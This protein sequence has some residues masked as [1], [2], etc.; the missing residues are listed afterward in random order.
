MMQEADRE[1]VRQAMRFLVASG[2][3][4]GSL[5]DDLDARVDDLV[6]GA[7]A[8]LRAEI[9]EQVTADLD[10]PARREAEWDEE[11]VNDRIDEAFDELW[12]GEV[13]ALQNV[14]YTPDEAWDDVDDA[15]ALLDAPRGAA[16]WLATETE[17]AVDGAGLRILV[18]GLD[19]APDAELLDEVVGVLRKYGVDAAA[20]GPS[21]VTVAPFRWQKRA[22]TE[23]G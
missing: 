20:T 11:T 21:E 5:L 19:R 4:D 10:A 22:F 14:G 23:P 6:D 8:A 7:D 3:V 12:D 13:V 18:A 9:R 17:R 2:F 16:L 15:A 1:H